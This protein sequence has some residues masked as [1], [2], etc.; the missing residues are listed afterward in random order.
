MPQVC[1]TKVGHIFQSDNALQETMKE[2]W[3]ILQSLMCV[4]TIIINCVISYVELCS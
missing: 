1:I 2:T 3:E 4:S